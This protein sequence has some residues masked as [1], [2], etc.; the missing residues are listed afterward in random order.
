MHAPGIE[1]E[2]G[3]CADPAC[4]S[5][6]PSTDLVRNE[7]AYVEFKVTN[8]AKYANWIPVHKSIKLGGVEI[9]PE[10]LVEL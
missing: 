9:I 7:V 2:I 4:T 10:N 5:I 6:A 1:T 8:P 3:I